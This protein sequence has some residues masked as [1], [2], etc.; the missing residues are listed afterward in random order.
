MRSSLIVVLISLVC[1]ATAVAK[2]LV[3][4]VGGSGQ[5]GIE[6]INALQQSGT[7]DIRATTRN[8]ERTK[9]RHSADIEWVSMDVQDLDGIRTAFAGADFV[10]STIGSASRSGPNAPEFVDYQGVKNMVGIAKD[11]GVKQFV[12][13]S[14]ASAGK[15]DR[16]PNVAVNNVLVWKWL[17][18]D[19][20]RDS[21]LPYTVVRPVA[22]R[23]EPRGRRGINFGGMGSY[24]LGYIARADAAAVMVASLNNPDAL[25]KT[26]EIIGYDDT[27][28]ESW[29]DSF[30]VIPLDPKPFDTGEFSDGQ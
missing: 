6:V 21:G 24:D 26:I 1:T 28:P 5:S 23:N 29:E 10:I 3:V 20:L 11:Y 15:I 17:G 14:A 18:E 12:L 16:M 25:N 4:V 19:Y 7:Y 8:V 9:E 22:L 2:D 13:M 30:S 27:T